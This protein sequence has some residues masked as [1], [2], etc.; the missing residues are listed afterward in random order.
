MAPC[1]SAARTWAPRPTTSRKVAPSE[2]VGRADVGTVARS[3][4][5]ALWL[6]ARERTDEREEERGSIPT[7]R[8]A[9][10]PVASSA[11]N[12]SDRTSIR[13][14]RSCRT[15]LLPNISGRTERCRRAPRR[16][17]AAPR[18]RRCRT[19]A[20]PPAWSAPAPRTRKQRATP[21]KVRW[22]AKPTSTEALRT[23]SRAAGTPPRSTRRCRSASVR[24]CA[25]TRRRMRSEQ[26]A[27]R[28]IEQ[29]RTPRGHGS[30]R[31]SPSPANDPNTLVFRAWGQRR[32]CRG[33]NNVRTSHRP[34]TSSENS[35]RSRRE[36][37]SPLP[38]P[39]VASPRRG[40]PSRGRPRGQTKGG[41][42]TRDVEGLP[43]GGRCQRRR[44]EIPPQP[45]L[46]GS[47]KM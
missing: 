13:G 42:Q 43:V 17:R 40:K 37:K 25:G 33:D 4:R 16:S 35:P 22:G 24:R 14:S 29:R 39:I 31:G 2:G 6:G 47:S 18:T 1:A 38:R 19:D 21:T 3:V 20:W 28:A 23:G 45:C 34:R 36:P 15:S 10:A 46:P 11:K 7:C 12:V 26:R 41:E 9:M 32:R 5:G 8:P 30:G 44:S 27:G